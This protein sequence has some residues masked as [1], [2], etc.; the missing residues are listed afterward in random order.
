[1]REQEKKDLQQKLKERTVELNSLKEFNKAT[2]QNIGF[3]IKFNF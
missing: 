2:S 1:L 3:V